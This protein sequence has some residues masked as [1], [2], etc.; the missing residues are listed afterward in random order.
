MPGPGAFLLV[1]FSTKFIYL[2]MKNIN[3]KP[4]FVVFGRKEYES[5][6]NVLPDSYV[7]GPGVFL[8]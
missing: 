1:V 7:P 3:N 2:M 5:F 4:G 8:I 6:F